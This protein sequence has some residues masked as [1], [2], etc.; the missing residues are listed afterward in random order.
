MSESRIER[1]Q[2]PRAVADIPIQLTPREDAQPATLK[3]IS[4]SGIRCQFAEAI[5]EMTLLQINLAL[6]GQKQPACI[7]GAVV[8]CEKLRDQSPPTYELG[9]FF[10][11][12]SEEARSH[13]KDFVAAELQPQA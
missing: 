1:R 3:D 8:R 13:I 2:A 7:Q 11:D 6:P 5:S 12:M 9:I 4:I 10:T